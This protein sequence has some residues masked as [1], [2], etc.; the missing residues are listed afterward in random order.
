M[1]HLTRVVQAYQAEIALFM[2]VASLEEEIVGSSDFFRWPNQIEELIGQTSRLVNQAGLVIFETR[3]EG[4][5]SLK[6]GAF[7]FCLLDLGQ[8]LIQVGPNQGRGQ[9][10]GFL[11]KKE[12]TSILIQ[13]VENGMVNVHVEESFL[14][15]KKGAGAP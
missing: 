15:K 13:D 7:G 1:G 11:G 8:E 3:P 12:I 4:A 2:V 5:V 6:L 9:V 10:H 14:V